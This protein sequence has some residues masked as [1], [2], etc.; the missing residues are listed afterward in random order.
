MNNTD[1]I[2]RLINL[3]GSDVLRVANTYMK[4]TTLAE[5]IFQEVFVKAFKNINF[6]RK[7]SS[8]K[9]WLIRITINT[10]KDYLKSAWHNKVT[11]IEDSFDPA[12]SQNIEKEL[13]TEENKNNIAKEILNLP[14]KYKEIL[15]LYYYQDFSSKE[16]S[17]ILH[18]PET[19]VR[20][21]MK[22][23]REILKNKLQVTLED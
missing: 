17:Q 18:L 16:I 2:E 10:C 11:S 7:E 22:R 12:S 20:T 15:I 4:N 23:A 1:K 3:Y 9:T 8:E 6:F 19:S 13:I 21:R 5:D 14:D